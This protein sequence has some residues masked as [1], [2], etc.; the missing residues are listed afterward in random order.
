MLEKT[1]ERKVLVSGD[2]TA[3]LAGATIECNDFQMI[4]V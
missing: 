1:K 4:A 3:A 2:F